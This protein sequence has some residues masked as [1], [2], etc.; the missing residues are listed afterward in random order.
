[1]LPLAV[2]ALAPVLLVPQPGFGPDASCPVAPR[3]GELVRAL[4][5]ERRPDALRPWLLA[6]SWRP[7]TMRVVPRS[8]IPSP[9]EIMSSAR[10]YLGTPYVWGGNGDGGYDCSGFV[11]KVFADNGYD[12]PRGGEEQFAVGEPV[13]YDR[14]AVG[15]L[16]FFAKNPGGSRVSHVALYAGDGEIIHAATGKGQVTFDRLGSGYYK[17]R[18]IG[19][20]RL[21]DSPPGVYANS[22]GSARDP[23]RHAIARAP[24]GSGDA[25]VGG[26]QAEPSL[27]G[28]V[29]S[30][31][32]ADEAGS[33][34]P[35]FEDEPRPP[36]LAA[37]AAPAMAPHAGPRTLWPDATAFGVRVGS[38]RLDDSAGA[39]AVIEASYFDPESAV[40]LRLGA[41]FEAPFSGQPR[42]GGGGSSYATA[43]DWSKILQEARFGQPGA[44][45]FAEV[46]RTSSATLAHGQLCR[47][48]TP[49]LASRTVPDY[50]LFPDELSLVARGSL[51]AGTLEL[52]ADDVVRPRVLGAAVTGRPLAALGAG[53]EVLRGLGV[54]VT[55]AA[56]VAAPYD[57]PDGSVV[58]RTVHGLGLSVDLAPWRGSP[59]ELQTYLDGALLAHGGT[60]S[61]GAAAGVL[62]R[63]VVAGRHALRLR[64]EGSVG[65]SGYVPGYFDATYALDR[66]RLAA[67]DAS[68]P[69]ITK[70]R[71]LDELVGSGS[72]W[73]AL[74]DVGYQL[75]RR[76][77]LG[78]AYEDVGALAG[79]DGAAAYLGKSLFVY[80]EARDLYLPSSRRALSFYVAYHR[81][82]FRSLLPLLASSAANEYLFAN[83]SLSVSSWVSVGGSVR[84]AF[85][86]ASGQSAAVDALVDLTVRYEL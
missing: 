58:D 4:L 44:D 82:N 12:I 33:I 75:Q 11:N 54:G 71:L 26:G 53:P 21:L 73:G 68:A 55:W 57:L 22:D 17:A 8:S 84:R 16:V 42:A 81:R 27:D 20:R 78:I 10:S 23:R 6:W 29:A 49:S 40:A 35:R 46:S 79:G 7:P 18:F 34:P 85:D 59:V 37:F 51:D 70:L 45:V 50:T 30:A 67:P 32:A 5:L 76:F 25:A 41:P 13:D 86:V 62:V 72:R 38:G 1:M 2:L 63:G 56:D 64:L 66:R 31:L 69:G 9:D 28:V 19:G 24:D 77:G 48:F 43:H 47:G 14:L 61:G 52:F 39:L 80:L 3:D 74:V 83:A 15:D 60:A 65:G 36:Q